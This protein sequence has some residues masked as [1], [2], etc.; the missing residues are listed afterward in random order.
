MAKNKNNIVSWLMRS[1]RITF[2]MVMVI[3]VIGIIGFDKM[4]KAEFPD[5]VIRQGVVVAIYPGATAKEV[6]VQVAKPLERYLFTFDEVKRKKTT[7]TSSNGMCVVMVELEDNVTNKDEVWSKLKHGLNS[8][9]A[10]SL[11]AGVLALAVNDDF[12]S[13]SALLIA[14]ESKNRSY[15]DLKKYSDILS[16]AL[17]RI[18]SVS[19]VVLYGDTKEQI[20]ITVDQQRLAAYGIGPHHAAVGSSV[21]R[22]DDNGRCDNWQ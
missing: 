9:K 10:Q 22:N 6:E 20:T 5:F 3:F 17:R 1:Y 16:D 18:P 14:I 4:G 12:G 19:N 2:M 11:P 13:A 7:T 21:C 15:R 8:F